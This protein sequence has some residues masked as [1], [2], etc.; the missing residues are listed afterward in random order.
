MQSYLALGPICMV[1]GVTNRLMRIDAASDYSRLQRAV[2]LYRY[3]KR[4]MK[5]MG[6]TC[7][8]VHGCMAFE[9]WNVRSG[10]VSDV[11]F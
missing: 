4:Y 5:D 7:M 6:L 11:I 8:G 9:I 3:S 2:S 10:L 1:I